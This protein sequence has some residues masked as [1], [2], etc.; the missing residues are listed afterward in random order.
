MSQSL[1]RLKRNLNEAQKR[2][3]LA[4]KELSKIQYEKTLLENQLKKSEV[5]DSIKTLEI[6]IRCNLEKALTKEVQ[7]RPE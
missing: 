2:A 4:T 1:P 3:I 7:I 5:I 6:N